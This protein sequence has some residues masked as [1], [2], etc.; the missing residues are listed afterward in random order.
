[1]HQVHSQEGDQDGYRLPLKLEKKAGQCCL[2]PSGVHGTKNQ[3]YCREHSLRVRYCGTH[4]R[5]RRRALGSVDLSPKAVAAPKSLVL[6]RSFWS[7]RRR[8]GRI[9]ISGNKA[10]EVR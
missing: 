3:K 8:Y 7:Y 5:Q 4:E 10:L 1:M 9:V 2:L 6:D